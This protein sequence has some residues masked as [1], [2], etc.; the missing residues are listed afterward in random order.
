MSKIKVLSVFGTRPEAIK[1]SPVVK[2]LEDSQKHQSIV[3]LT[4]QHRQMLDQMVALFE[5]KIDYDLDIMKHNQTLAGITSNVVSKLDLILKK[6]KPDWVLVQG[7]TTSCFAAALA[8]FYN[9]IKV[10]HVEAG[11]RTYNL[12]SPFPEEANRQLVSRISALHFAPTETSANNLIA[13]GINKGAIVIT[14]NTVIDA[15]L[16]VKDKIIWRDSWEKLFLSAANVIH[17][18][19][20]YVMV[21]G[22][23]RENHGNGFLNI[24]EALHSLALKYTQWHFIYP[25]HLNPNVRKPVFDL[26]SDIP[27]I[28]LL[29]PLDYE[30]FVFLLMNCQLV[31][32]DSGGVQEEAPTLGKPV[33]VMRNTTERPEGVA[34]GTAKLVGTEVDNII[35]QVSLLI[36]NPCEYQR[37]SNAVNPYGNG[38]SS[39]R[40]LEFL[41]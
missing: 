40:I 30:P 38:E 29:E 35:E 31:L 3:C 15:L 8:A 41:V 34:A 20:N 7:D 36:D 26:L 19:Q 5:L 27:N 16:W 12:Q 28:H 17:S 9:N 10:G 13:E 32:T 25:V 23:R 37:M 22:H 21:T 24:C 11:L 18:R 1:M 6:E 2:A 39:Q 33:L 14:G 4:G